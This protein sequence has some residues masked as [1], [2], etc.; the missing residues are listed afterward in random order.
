MVGRGV[1]K[2]NEDSECGQ[3][4]YSHI[5]PEALG[6]SVFIGIRADPGRFSYAPNNG[7]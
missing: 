6:V 2:V 1:S 7:L 5:K 4:G 3:G